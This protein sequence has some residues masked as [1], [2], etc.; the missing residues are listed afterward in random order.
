MSPPSRGVARAGHRTEPSFLLRELLGGWALS[1]GSIIS[2][3]HLHGPGV[4]SGKEQGA[5]LHCFDQAPWG[6]FTMERL[7]SWG[8]GKIVP[9][10][11]ITSN[12]HETFL[13]GTPQTFLPSARWP[14]CR[15]PAQKGE[16][17]GAGQEGSEGVLGS[18]RSGE[19]L[20][21]LSQAVPL[22]HLPVKRR[23]MLG[24]KIRFTSQEVH[25][26][27]RQRG[28]GVESPEA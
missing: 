27:A 9:A 6:F 19:E 21:G 14:A 13:A 25:P 15:C 20:Q 28:E 17:P 18:P 5:G 4:K 3:L 24:N 1:P 2:L 26:A 10:A 23:G 22:L 12:G 11:C 7:G 16:T 8:G